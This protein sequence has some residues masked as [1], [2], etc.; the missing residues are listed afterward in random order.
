M[1]FILFRGAIRMFKYCFGMFLEVLNMLEM[2]LEAF[3]VVRLTQKYVK[4]LGNE[5]YSHTDTNSPKIHSYQDF[6]F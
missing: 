2:I 4:S 5:E 1:N 6:E 3:K